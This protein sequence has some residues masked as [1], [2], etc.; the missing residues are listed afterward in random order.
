MED[1][2]D[3][4]DLLLEWVK[5][6]ISL[7]DIPRFSDV[8]EYSARNFKSLKKTNVLKALRLLPAYE[9]TSNQSRKRLPGGKYR[10]VLVSSLGNLH[11]DLGFFSVRREYPTPKSY[12]N[13]YLVCKDTLSRY[14][15]V[16]ILTK[17]RAADSIVKA[18]E[19]VK[20]KFK[21]QNNGFHIQ[22]VAFDKER[23]VMGNKVQHYF[24]ENNIKFIAFQQSASKSKM[25]ENSI[26]LIRTAIARLQTIPGNETKGWWKLIDQA[27]YMLNNQ[28]IRIQGKNLQFTPS[29]VSVENL[30]K[31]REALEKAG[32]QYFFAQFAIAR[33]LVKTW[34]FKIGDIVRVKEIAISSAALG[35]KRS[36][37]SVAPTRFIVLEQIATYTASS[38]IQ[39]QYRCRSFKDQSEE[40]FDEDDLVFAR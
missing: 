3:Q 21:V 32:K 8:L 38:T 5:S 2:K 28:P 10:P 29:Q 24:K 39:N 7:G 6:R 4:L 27:V 14:L 36:E 35:Q 26:R 22:S 17:D 23:S 34:K 25:A 13:G 18:F 15:Y 40:T 9:F 1:K 16:S 30:P 31:F 20:Y 37:I 11:C 33:Q 19:D 12:Q